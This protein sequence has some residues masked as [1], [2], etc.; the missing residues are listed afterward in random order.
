MT[1]SDFALTTPYT[2][3]I[4]LGA[5]GFSFSI[6]D[7]LDYAT[8]SY[9]PMDVEPGISLTANM[10]RLL[11]SNEQ[12]RGNYK[13]VDVLLDTTSYTTMPF[14]LFEDEHAESIYR[15]CLPLKRGET[16][17]YDIMDRSNAVVLYAMERTAYQL[18]GE[19]YPKFHLHATVTPVIE[20]LAG[21]SRIGSP[22]RLYLRLHGHHVSLTAFGHGHLLMGVT[23]PCNT[24]ED[25]AYYTMNAWSEMG[26]SPETDEVF[27]IGEE[28]QMKQR[29][30]EHLQFFLKKVAVVTPVAEFNRSTP[31]RTENLP[32][33][34][35]ALVHGHLL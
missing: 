16:V 35:L 9:H 23:Y 28:E 10:R 30:C 5:D 17:F 12:L 13:R 1:K 7:P 2:L 14:E 32:Y 4:R 27:L 6:H 33:D 21:K 19:Y 24:V 22:R 15:H 3:S 29:V 34:M 31:A 18:L 8:F 11:S 26:F 25:V 20:H